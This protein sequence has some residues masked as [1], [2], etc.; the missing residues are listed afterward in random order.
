[1]QSLTHHTETKDAL[2]G[3][4]DRSLLKQLDEGFASRK[5]PWT[6]LIIDVDHFKLVNDIY[7]HLTG[8]DILAHVGQTISINLKKSDHALRFGG[9][10]FL[11]VLPETD[12]NSALDLAQ[13]L[14]Y[15]LGNREFP[16]GLRVSAS[17]GVAESQ[18]SHREM[19]DVIALAD[20]ALYR[21]KEAGRGRFLLADDLKVFRD[22]EPDFTHMV[23]RRDELQLLRE[24]L[25]RS[26]SGSS[27]FCSI[28]GE[29]GMG[30]TRLVEELSN[31]CQFKQTPLLKTDVHPVSEE[32]NFL[33]VNELKL[34]LDNLDDGE[35]K[36][37]VRNTGQ[38]EPGTADHLGQYGFPVK[39][40]SVPGDLNET[41][42]R[43]R[44]DLSRILS[45]LS[46]IKPFV[47]V[48][49][50]LQWA[51]PESVGYMAEVLS[52]ASE[53]GFFC[54]AISRTAEVLGPFISL[55]PPSRRL[56]IHLNP[57]SRSDVRTMLFFALK[58]P[59]VPVDVIDYMS[60]QSG[61]N[62]RFLQMLINWC[63]ESGAVGVGNGR[64]ARWSEPGEDATPPDI[65]PVLDSIL[66]GF[67]EEQLKVLKRSALAGRFLTLSLLSHLTGMEELSLAE[68]LDDFV[69]SGLLLD[70]G[71][72][73]QF[74]FGVMSSYLVSLISPSLR[75]ILHE[76]TAAALE[77]EAGELSGDLLTETARHYCCSRNTE[78]ALSFSR[79]AAIQTFREGQHSQS[80]HWYREYLERLPA[81]T[82]AGELFRV[83][84]NMGT[85]FSI[86][87][88]AEEADRHMNTALEMAS[89]P[90][91]RAAVF[92]RLGDSYKRRSMY[93]KAMEMFDEV[94]AIGHSVEH[95]DNILTGSMTGALLESSF[96]SRLQGRRGEAGKKLEDAKQ[97]IDGSPGEPDGSLE[98]LY[99]ARLADLESETGTP[100]R[101]LDHYRTALDIS[102]THNDPSMEA[103][104][105]N[106]MHG[107]LEHGGHYTEMLDTLK[108]VVRLNNRLDD[109][110]GLAIAYYNL[111]E[112]YTNL[113]MLDL[114]RRYFQLYI[115]LNSRIQN[116][117]GMG[118]GQL[119]LGR[120]FMLQGKYDKAEKYLLNACDIF[121]EL[122]CT[123]TLHHSRL[124]IA[125]V[126]IRRSDLSRAQEILTGIENCDMSQDISNRFIHL[127]GYLLVLTG[128]SVDRGIFMIESSIRNAEN[129]SP[130]DVVFMYG[131]L[132]RA[133][134]ASGSDEQALHALSNGVDILES[135]ISSITTESIRNGILSRADVKEYLSICENR[136]IACVL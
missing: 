99:Y 5:Y 48:L 59:G 115:E 58:S 90:V 134:M 108:Q 62:T 105:L 57:L 94:V 125:A 76:R 52:E 106:N 29:Q 101:A 35:L 89:K 82:D 60:S 109:Q 74:K 114:S 23:G 21:A 69:G 100:A 56:S 79:M 127:R 10:E 33:V 41:R 55:L 122:N 11:V 27:M 83:H 110:L 26:L 124:E 44:K 131:N 40:R 88:K 81:D 93:S 72:G 38:V 73:Y 22:T 66:E 45:A 1:M 39:K 85:L 129:L 8:D 136:G 50:N 2:T 84:L 30:K 46:T 126:R 128:E 20:Q 113:N 36:K 96:I 120:L 4:C 12:G 63:I 91:D 3:L 104:I 28:T 54:I 95:R 53:P 24:T 75:S 61:G 51:S 133:Y 32:I 121:E 42:I 86:T 130:F 16:G 65:R 47:M 111:A 37:V 19:K 6:L 70:D 112:A 132:Y 80:I 135:T 15:E 67:S 87:G 31:Y 43:T 25:D 117:L 92:Y 118:Y 97:L 71:Q 68:I 34:C 18:P 116:R 119:G 49:D 123:E 14:L 107:L 77:Q 102:I 9:D 64:A 13:R 7:G 78:K 98:G 103:L 17:M